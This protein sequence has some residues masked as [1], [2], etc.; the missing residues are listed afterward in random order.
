MRDGPPT[1]AAEGTGTGIGTPPGPPQ[2]QGGGAGAASEQE[3]NHL[4]NT[5]LGWT[6][7][8]VDFARGCCPV[9][10]SPP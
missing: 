5:S 6:I 2:L 1:G 10:T 3:G 8:L 4:N 9:S 7:A